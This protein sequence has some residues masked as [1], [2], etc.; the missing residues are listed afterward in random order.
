MLVT[1]G[2]R[3]RL[4]RVMPDHRM[5]REQFFATLAGFDEDGLRKVLWTL[6]WR[7]SAPVRQ[8]IEA[9][10]TPAEHRSKGGQDQR[11]LDAETLALTPGVEAR[12]MPDAP[13]AR[14]CHKYA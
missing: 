2:S 8:R 1:V 3:A 10:L 5:S 11:S 7:G 4:A 13:T 6:Y 9:M 14:G 12:A